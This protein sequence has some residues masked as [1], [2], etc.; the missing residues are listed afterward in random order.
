MKFLLLLL[1][2]LVPIL[3]VADLTENRVY[4]RIVKADNYIAQGKDKEAISLLE[5]VLEIDN[6]N[7]KAIKS[8]VLLCVKAEEYTCASN[9]LVLLKPDELAN[10]YSANMWYGLREYAKALK[11]ASAS[12][13]ASLLSQDQ[14]VRL[15]FIGLKSA[16]YVKDKA[17]VKH[18]LLEMFHTGERKNYESGFDDVITLMIPNN[19]YTLAL[20]EID[21][22]TKKG[23]TF[24]DEKLGNWA[25]AYQEAK[26]YQ[27]ALHIIGLISNPTE[28]Y[29]KQIIIYTQAGEEQKAAQ[30]MKKIY[31]A[32]PTKENR[33]KLIYL[34]EKAG[35]TKE[36]QDLY[37]ASLQKVCDAN[38]LRNVLELNKISSKRYDLLKQYAPFECLDNEEK[39]NLDME[40][41]EYYADKH[42]NSK[43]LAVIETLQQSVTLNDKQNRM[44]IYWLSKLD[45]K[46]E[47]VKV[48]QK[49]YAKNPSAKNK[50]QLMYLYGQAGMSGKSEAMHIQTMRKGCD[51][52]SLIFLLSVQNDTYA[53]QKY[54]PYSCLEADE[55]FN[56]TMRLVRYYQDANQP[57][58]ARRVL[59]ELTQTKSLT[60]DNYLEIAMKYA[61]LGSQSLS[62][63]YAKIASKKDNKN[64][65]A[66]KQLGY[67]YEKNNQPSL[68][69]K[70]YKKALS[71]DPK[72]T[73]LYLAIGSQ[74]AKLHKYKETLD[75]WDRYLKYH[76]SSSLILQSAEFALLIPDIKRAER[77]MNRL[78][79]A[80]KNKAYQYY[81]TKSRI[82][83]ANKQ[84]DKERQYYKKAISYTNNK[85][86]HYAELGFLYY[87]DEQ[88][89]Q[90]VSAF[91]QAVSYDRTLKYN[92]ALGYSYEKLNLNEETTNTFM[93]SVDMINEMDEPDLAHRYK[94][95][96]TVA[97]NQSFFGYFAGVTRLDNYN[98]VQD[99]A[100]LAIPQGSY[101]GF[102]LLELAY[103][104]DALNNYISFYFRGLGGIQNQNIA[105]EEGSFQP[106]LGIRYKP[107][108]DQNLTF[109]IEHLFEG[110]D[111]TRE[112]NMLR[113]SWGFFDDYHFHPVES[114]YWHKNLF[115]DT[116]Y[117]I[118]D[119]I[120]SFYA[121]YEYGYVKKVSA[122]TALMPYL[123]TSASMHNDNY[124]RD[125]IK[126]FD[127]GIGVSWFFW[128]NERPYKPHQFTGR[129]SIEARQALYTNTDDEHTIRAKLEF[130]F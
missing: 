130:M 89:E 1:L 33:T 12:D 27:D 111:R 4:P 57:K 99:T 124:E 103:R 25:Y 91:E 128:L 56:Y 109:S 7:Q 97:H 24:S 129:L 9:Y 106:S 58:K 30:S 125:Q 122:E 6:G 50:K 15:K 2:F 86:H 80:P 94:L 73:K 105:L 47:A 76:Y 62:I 3:G 71:L 60:S 83:K 88:Y 81:M 101:N 67:S 121:N 42:E 87:N 63:K 66:M 72:D 126:L 120:Y 65:K 64:A 40:L 59:D 28:R 70:Y 48:M 102:S 119:E 16:I 107:Y 90:A 98:G 85:A 19:F 118:D 22:A 39:Y 92:N 84:V 78:N 123:S 35:M 10:Y 43:A 77:Y 54:Y 116:A 32:E 68:A 5:E 96:Q 112:D 17:K 38:D 29:Q 127:A 75:Y 21:Y 100:S 36:I 49:L 41:V 45:E 52:K 93:L 51:R 53:L 13:N 46:E 104:P 14:L 61:V 44:I 11:A 115:L 31:T 82:A 110:G 34:Y 108:R 74:Y 8:L 117:Y 23:R 20:E 26:H 69:I 79:K 114:E 55:R 113:A 37:S 18:Y 95:K